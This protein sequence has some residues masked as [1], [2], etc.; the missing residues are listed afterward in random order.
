M[1]VVRADNVLSYVWVQNVDYHG[2]Q[3][4]VEPLA[5]GQLF[6]N[7]HAMVVSH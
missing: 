1:Y 5:S 7:G 2:Y 4:D 3:L 6:N